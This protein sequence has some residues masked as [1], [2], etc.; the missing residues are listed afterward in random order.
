MAVTFLFFE[1]QLFQLPLWL[2]IISY[3]L[4]IGIINAYNFM[5]GINGIT[6]LYSLGL[7]LTLIWLNLT[8]EFINHYF[9]VATA[10]AL[11]V[12]LYFNFRYK[13][14]CF[15][16]DVGS[17]S[18]AFIIIF[19]IITLIVKT[20]DYIYVMLLA[21]YGVDTILTIFIR[22]IKGENIFEA[23]RLHTYQILS[24]EC[25]ISHRLVAFTYAFLQV[26]INLLVVYIASQ[27]LSFLYE[28]GF[29]IILLLALSLLY[30]LARN[31]KNSYPATNII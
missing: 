10:F 31:T 12:F 23:H 1:L 29:A 20:N 13:A 3:I 5:D 6:G 9:L 15:A 25:G 26:I 11:T 24:N 17:V 28:M 19:A 27:N 30:A 22:L 8:I 2:I 16:G 18:M 21:V 14:R 7:I 4:V